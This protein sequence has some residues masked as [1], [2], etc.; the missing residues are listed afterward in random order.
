MTDFLPFNKH[1]WNSS[2][3]PLNNYQY[4]LPDMASMFLVIAPTLF[5]TTFDE[6]E[7]YLAPTL[8]Q[9]QPW[10]QTG[11]AEYHNT[12]TVLRCDVHNS[13]YHTT[14]SF[15]NGEQDVSINNVTDGTD[16]PMLTTMRLMANYNT[17]NTTDMSLQP[18]PCPPPM[19]T[20]SC[21]YHSL[22]LST[23]SY[24]AVM[25]SFKD[26]LV[27]TIFRGADS[28]NF[29]LTSTTQL[30]STI[31]A[32]APELAFLE[33]TVERFQNSKAITSVQQ[34][35]T[36][37][38]QQP[39]IGLV[40]TAVAPKVTLPIQQALEQLFQNITISLMSAPEFQYVQRFFLSRIDSGQSP[41][42]QV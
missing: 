20:F 11:L 39:F 28:K 36:M 30:G 23:L 16:T 9:G 6:A 8:C 32:E 37:W 41:Y 22:V 26:L 18:G 35:A 17:S 15:V 5:N 1:E 25:N 4:I 31:L 19:T 33:P 40:N 2:K 34:S 27:E 42:A 7:N 29:I 12:S 13:T 3:G 24:Q 38:K 21:L 14:F 10:Y